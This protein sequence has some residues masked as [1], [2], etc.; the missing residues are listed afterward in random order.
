MAAGWN[1]SRHAALTNAPETVKSG[2][3]HFG[4]YFIYNPNADVAF[5]HIYDESGTVTVGSTTPKASF[6][7]PGGAGANIEIKRSVP[8]LNSIK[9]AAT[10]TAGGST[11]PTSALVANIYYT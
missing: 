10:T 2:Q 1:V 9:V 11:A 3:G 7:I 6:G 5:L 4:G 8:C